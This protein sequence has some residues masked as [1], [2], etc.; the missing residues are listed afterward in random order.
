LFFTSTVCGKGGEQD[1]YRKAAN[2][3]RKKHMSILLGAGLAGPGIQNARG[4][5][6][7]FE[8]LQPAVRGGWSRNRRRESRP[9]PPPRRSCR[10]EKELALE[11]TLYTFLQILSVHSFE[12][13]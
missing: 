11:V 1:G 6:A 8:R 9:A 13:T 12:K 3:K 4:K 10:N 7:D 5:S 2:I